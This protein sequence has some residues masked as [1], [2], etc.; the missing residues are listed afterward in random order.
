MQTVIQS[1]LDNPGQTVVTSTNRLSRRLIHDYNQHQLASGLQAWVTPDV[2]SWSAWV[3]RE[4]QQQSLQPDQQQIL[5]G[6]AQSLQLWQSIIEADNHELINAQ[7]TA[8]KAQAARQQVID[9][10]LDLQDDNLRQWFVYDMDASQW[11]SW[12]QRYEQQLQASNWLDV[13]AMTRLLVHAMREQQHTLSQPVCLYGFD[14]L[15]P[16]QQQL[17]QWLTVQGQS[18]VLAETHRP[19]ARAGLLAVDNPMQEIEQ[20]AAWARQQFEQHWQE[21]E[22]PIGVIVPNLQQ[23]RLEIERVFRE[24]FYPED[25]LATLND[26][27]LHTQGIRSDS[28][29]NISL[30]YSL[31]HEPLIATA[32]NLLSLCRHTFSYETFS[33]VLRSPFIAGAHEQRSVRSLLDHELR[34]QVSAEP[35]LRSLLASMP[36]DPQHEFHAYLNQ[37]A[38]LKEG[39]SHKAS[40]QTWVTRLQQCLSVFGLFNA[41]HQARSPYQYQVMQ[42][43]DEVWFEFS[44]LELVNPSLT[45]DQSIS[46]IGRMVQE[47]IFQS[48]AGELPVQILGTLEAAGLEF[49]SLW[50]MGMTE[51]NWPPPSSPNPF[52]PLRLQRQFAMPHCSAQHEFEYARQQTQ[53]FLQA[54][55]TL[56]FSYPRMH[57]DEV[58]VASPLVADQSEMPAITVE[59]QQLEPP[60][61]LNLLDEQ[62]PPVDPENYRAGSA[63]FRD[64]SQ[65]PFRAFVQHRLHASPAEEPLPGNDPRLRGQ[66]V[67]QVMEQ[68]WQQWKTSQQMHALSEEQLEAEVRQTIEQVL[69]A[70]WQGGNQDYEARRLF[71]LIMEWLQQEKQR[72]SFTVI[73]TERK[74]SAEIDQLKLKLYI[75]RIDQLTDGSYCIVDYKTGQA[76]ANAWIGDRP[77]EPQLP[78]YAFVQDD[79]VG[80][81]VF[82]NIRAGESRYVGLAR[83]HD[84]VG[85]GDKSLP[86]VKS[87]PVT[88]GSSLLKQYDSWDDMLEDWERTIT[89]LAKNH[90]QGDAQVDPKDLNQTC[91]YCDV[92]SVCRLFDWREE[93]GETE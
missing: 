67:H 52:I 83:D 91:R 66:L 40:P 71:T 77:D 62:G 44:R 65:C 34:Q 14:R 9:F 90:M 8:Q 86:D 63:V 88:R 51:Q 28:V 25:G 26:E 47:K 4:W 81:V 58:F 48:G 18:V 39:W 36:S 72:Q 21:G 85:A 43:M 16:L 49:S 78:L 82:A 75:D 69:Q 1:L 33:Q 53:R 93:E 29:V 84:L 13:P 12:H 46:I 35:G 38:Q 32:L 79:A 19:T 54:T 20:A 41:G 2:L 24:V 55:P 45:L 56:V 42:S 61:L 57:G 68:L 30:G 7:A 76:S 80:A 23:D 89:K 10:Q 50:V 74:T 11:L 87:I 3:Q 6:G 27:T 59:R 15:T 70:Q 73:A 37:L 60:A 17:Q 5:L 64:Q 31:R 92:M 22:A